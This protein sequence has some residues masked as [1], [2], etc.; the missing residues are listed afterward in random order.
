MLELLDRGRVPAGRGA[1]A[2]LISREQDLRRHIAELTREFE[3]ASPGGE[4]RGP[5][6]SPGRLVA[7]EALLQAQ[8]SY[9]DLLLEI[10]ERAPRHALL[11]SRSSSSWQ[12]VA[13]RLAA[14]E[15]FIEYL[16]DERGSL[17]F[18]IT[19]DTVVSVDL[20]VSQRELARLVDFARSTL[21]PRNAA[22]LDS[23]W[24]APL[25]LLY[26]DLMAPVESTGLLRNAR[27]LVIVPHAELHYLPF[28]ALLSTETGRFLVERYD[29]TVTP[30]ATIWLAL[31]ARRELRPT[32]GLLAYAPRPDLLPASRREVEGLAALAGGDARI[33]VGRGATEAAFLRE[34]PGRG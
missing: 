2:V 10:R 7:R 11:V 26:Q 8:E 22:R 14:D 24:R 25:R 17:A 21:A 32:S 1:S 12:D 5:D 15:A 4:E 27:R 31:A 6:L 13:G 28:A 16:T 3:V 9:A 18:V 19:P 33:V 29:L 23:L 20:G 30:S 34:A